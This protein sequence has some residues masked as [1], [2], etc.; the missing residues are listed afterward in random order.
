MKV[1]VGLALSSGGARGFAHV[2]VI[3]SLVKHNIP[4]DIISGVSAGALF[5]GIYASGATMEEIEKV[6]Y[7]TKYKDILP[8]IWDFSRKVSGG[9]VV[10]KKIDKFLN[11]LL[12]EEKIE[13]FP[14][15]F[16]CTATDLIS[17][18]AV[19]FDNGPA[20]IAIRASGAI[21]AIFK[22]IEYG[23]KYLVDGGVVE[24]MSLERV[25]KFGGNVNIGVDISRSTNILEKLANGKKLNIK[26]SVYSSFVLMQKRFTDIEFK[27]NKNFLRIRPKVDWIKS[28]KFG[29]EE[30]ARK[31][32]KEGE[33][34]MDK[35]IP[36]VKEMIKNCQKK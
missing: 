25:K 18:K 9:L 17:G 11:S 33:R 30:T 26:D 29:S 3:K 31:G 12:M 4:I 14:I 1:K 6:C 8:I 34:I 23:G 28:L 36:K 2:G 5:G 15:K 19:Y 16:T 27:E 10:G 13:N 32:I 21:P 20:S 22:P 24:P 7:S 35:N